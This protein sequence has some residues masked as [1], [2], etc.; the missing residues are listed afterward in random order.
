MKKQAK[1]YICIEGNI[2]AGKTTLCQMLSLDHHC[3][4]ILEEFADNPFLEYFYKDPGRYALS[5][6]LFFLAERQKQIQQDAMNTDLFL[7]FILSD[8]TI[9][10]S[11]LFARTNLPADEYK[12]FFKIYQ[13][14]THSLPKPDLIVYLHRDPQQVQSNI[15]K[16]GRMFEVHIPD[17]YLAKIQDSY[18]DF[19]KNQFALPVVIVDLGDQ[20]FT[21]D[22]RIYQE[23]EHIIFGSYHPGMHHIKIHN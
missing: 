14:L 3:K 20:D 18:F 23:L 13:A 19:F 22:K 15:A 5:V 9:I 11:L 1:P 8:Y 2:G 17:D 21:K 10:K 7:D 6:E 12:L 4:L 16:R